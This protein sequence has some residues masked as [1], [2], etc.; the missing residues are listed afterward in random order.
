ME[1]ELLHSLEH[2]HFMFVFQ[3]FPYTAHG[4]K[5]TALCQSIPECT[6]T[7]Q[8]QTSHQ[9]T[10]QS[11]SHNVRREHY[12]TFHSSPFHVMATT[13][14]WEIQWLFPL[15]KEYQELTPLSRICTTILYTGPHYVKWACQKKLLSTLHQIFTVC[16]G[17]KVG[18]NDIVLRGSTRGFWGGKGKEKFLTPISPPWGSGSAEIFLRDGD[19]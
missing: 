5:Q 10:L 17:H 9:L 13:V 7:K 4:H 16:R 2:V 8:T 15:V 19:L 12:A 14:F 6:H 18:N 3:S 1:A 11:T